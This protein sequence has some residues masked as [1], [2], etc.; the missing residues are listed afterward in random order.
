[1]DP[2]QQDNGFG[3][4]LKPRGTATILASSSL[5]RRQSFGWSRNLSSPT[6]VRW[7]VEIA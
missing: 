4:L 7:G 3:P 6:N 1:M 5:L 2:Q